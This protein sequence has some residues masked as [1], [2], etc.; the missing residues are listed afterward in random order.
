M[1]YKKATAVVSAIP[2]WC[3]FHCAQLSFLSD[4]PAIIWSPTR[5]VKASTKIGTLA[6]LLDVQ[7][8]TIIF[9]SEA[10]YVIEVPY[11]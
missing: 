6:Q 3:L 11:K 2:E 10:P 5:V 8:R 7:A 4:A 1:S 9:L